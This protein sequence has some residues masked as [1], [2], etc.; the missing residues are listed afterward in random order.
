MAYVNQDTLAEEDQNQE[1]GPLVP[2]GGGVAGANAPAAPQANTATKQKTPSNF[3]DLG[4]YLR[5]NQGQEF[6]SKLAG[7]VGEDIT[8]GQGALDTAETQYKERADA[9]TIQDNQ[10]LINQVD[11]NPEGIDKTAY[12]GLRD[13][14]YKGPNSFSDTQDLYNQAQ[15]QT[16]AAVGKANASKTEGGRFALLDNYFG[17]PNYSQGEKTLDNLLVQNDDNSK[18][19]FSQMQANAN[20][21][22]QKA[23]NIGTELG[24]YSAQAKGKTEATRNAARGALGI[25]DAGN[26]VEG[27]NLSNSQKAINDAYTQRTAD[28]DASYQGYADALRNR[29]FADV[30]GLGLQ[31]TGPLYNVGLENYLSKTNDLSPVSAATP[32]QF[33]K[34][35]TLSNLA[36]R[37]DA[38]LQDEANVGKYDTEPTVGY[39]F[40][41]LDSALGTAGQHFNTGLTPLES[42]VSNASTARNDAVNA[43]NRWASQI[44]NP[45]MLNSTF[46]RFIDPALSAKYGDITYGQLMSQLNGS[47]DSSVAQVNQYKQAGGLY[48]TWK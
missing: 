1:G 37:P 21:L 30:Q 47:Y 3:A 32:E 44:G 41:A 24:N 7:K 42:N 12:T 2:G 22:Q 40:S 26:V 39:D 36:D 23:D 34:F 29:R 11:T 38:W 28:Q 19:A 25:D 15:G 33:A 18:Q 13:A 45:E 17:R 27:G 14:E 4:E 43:G 5:V 35:K 31:N 16:G 6:G 20:Q 10:G 46:L 9:A 48:D 8:K